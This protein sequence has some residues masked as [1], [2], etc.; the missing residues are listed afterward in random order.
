MKPPATDIDLDRVE[1]PFQKRIPGFLGP[2][3]VSKTP[4]GQTNPTY[5]ISSPSGNYVLRRKPD[6]V[7]L[8]SAHAVEREYRV[9]TALSDTELPVPQTIFLCEDPDETGAVFFVMEHVPGRVFLD[10][11]LHELTC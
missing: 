10:P 6:G 8:P 11:R 9:M 2:L 3:D 4:Q 1:K 5:I 7:L